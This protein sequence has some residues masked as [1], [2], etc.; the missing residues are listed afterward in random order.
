MGTLDGSRAGTAPTCHRYTVRSPSLLCRGHGADFWRILF[1]DLAF[2]S[3]A[4]CLAAFVCSW[5]LEWKSVKGKTGG[6]DSEK[7]PSV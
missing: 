6:K 2:T 1:E 3:L 4:L 5:F 7:V